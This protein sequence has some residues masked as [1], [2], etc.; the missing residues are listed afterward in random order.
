MAK[1]NF[2]LK[3]R[4]GSGWDDYFPQTTTENV[5]HSGN[6]LDA[7]ITAIQNHISSRAKVF[8]HHYTVPT[9]QVM[10]NGEWNW[11]V[12]NDCTIQASDLP[13]GVYEV[14]YVVTADGRA[15]GM[16]T[17]QAHANGSEMSGNVS[18]SSAPLT[19]SKYSTVNG[20]FMIQ[21]DGST[22]LAIS[23]KAYTTAAFVVSS[24]DVYVKRIGDSIAER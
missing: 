23:L 10:P 3:I 16:F 9:T 21:L 14:N 12:S 2:K 6:P 24:A 19:S 18:R 8:S 7:I 5:M 13:A 22:G 4:N 11:V 15:N 20:N 1:K 17:I